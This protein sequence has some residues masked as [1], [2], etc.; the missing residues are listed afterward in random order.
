MRKMGICNRS[1]TMN[2][3]LDDFS[4]V[5]RTIFLINT[6]IP[7]LAAKRHCNRFPSVV[8]CNCSVTRPRFYDYSSLRSEIMGLITDFNG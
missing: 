8:H 6:V 5:S 4:P 3:I 7:N 2:N 1:M